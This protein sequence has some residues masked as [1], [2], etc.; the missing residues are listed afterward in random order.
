MINAKG[1]PNTRRAPR[2]LGDQLGGGDPRSLGEVPD[3]VAAVV[4]S[5]DQLPEL[6]EC[7]FHDDAVVRMRSADALEK[8]ARVR[9]VWLQPFVERLLGE[10]AAIDQPSVQWHLAQLLA[11]VPLD[12]GQR[13]RAVDLLKVNLENATD[14]LVLNLTMDSLTSLAGEDAA[15]RSWLVPVLLRRCADPRPSVAKR[16]NRCLARL[17]SG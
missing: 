2:R 12:A 3:V 8:V 15:L 11:E 4:N 13:R 16:A 1:D 17:R 10:V 5:R 9:P 6:F 14:W 7:L